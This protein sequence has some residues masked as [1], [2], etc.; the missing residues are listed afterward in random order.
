M[1]HSAQSTDGCVMRD[2]LSHDC[3]PQTSLR[4]PSRQPSTDPAV[5]MPWASS[6]AL[7]PQEAQQSPP[8]PNTSSSSRP[9]DH[10]KVHRSLP[11]PK[12]STYQPSPSS[13]P[14]EPVHWLT[15]AKI[16][17]GAACYVLLLLLAYS[18]F[19]L[20]ILFSSKRDTQEIYPRGMMCATCAE[21]DRHNPILLAMG[22]FGMKNPVRPFFS[23]LFKAWR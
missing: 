18:S 8:L 13:P 6:R 11:F 4:S 17:L 20:I 5:N 16:I 23:T 22:C 3:G 14:T 19:A 2:S 9:K 7:G 1:G 15:Q 10:P 21:I 12:T